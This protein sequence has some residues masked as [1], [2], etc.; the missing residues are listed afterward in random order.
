MTPAA[1]DNARRSDLPSSVPLLDVNRGNAILRGEIL[2][3][4]A[5]VVDSGR[6]LYG[7]DVSRLEESVAA[8]CDSRY[9]IGCASG[10]DALLL[11]L[12]A[13]DV[14]PGDEV[15]VPS[16]TFF[17]T[18]S[19]VWRLGARVVFADIDPVTFNLD[20]AKVEEAIT[21]ATR[22]IIPVHLYGQCADMEALLEIARHNDVKVIEDAAQAIGAEYRGRPAGSLG[23]VGCIS[24]YP[25]KNLG[26][27]G[28]GGMLVTSDEPLAEKLRRLAAHGMKTRY[29]HSLV[30]INSRLDSIQAAVLNVKLAQLGRW[31]NDRRANAQRY[32]ELLS[33]SPLDQRLVLPKE[34]PDRYHVWNQYTIRVPGGHRDELRAKLTERNVGSEVYYP[35][36]LHL[37]ECF[38]TLG[39]RRGSLPVTERIC[40]EALSLPIFPELTE[41]EQDRVVEVIHDALL[42]E[43][44]AA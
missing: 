42:S 19:C 16:F 24:F 11:A 9:A 33:A 4:I 21:P 35:V 34:L 8:I 5:R 31:T 3:A 30:G 7:P 20:P 2:E 27:M 44:A 38:R 40:H 43:R 6:F 15:I 25:T 17:A 23:D 22:A 41:A 26:A 12:M 14:G 18:A 37:Q 29:Y 39:Y 1:M 36:P 13:Y 32:H 10:S 28:D